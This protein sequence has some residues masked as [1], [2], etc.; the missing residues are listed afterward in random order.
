MLPLLDPSAAWQY[1]D[2]DQ[3]D[4]TQLGGLDRLGASAAIRWLIRP[5]VARR[6]G[7][8]LSGAEIA[9]IHDAWRLAATLAR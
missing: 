8:Q 5:L 4:I 6:R 7:V 3:V 2:A 9:A 1:L